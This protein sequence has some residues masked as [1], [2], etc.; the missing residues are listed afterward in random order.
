[1]SILQPA[2]EPVTRPWLMRIISGLHAGASRPLAEQE[3]LL[4]GSGDDCDVVLADNGVARH[5][6]LVALTGD[7]FTIRALDA[8]L[9]VGERPLYP[10]DPVALQP[11]Q[12]IGLGEAALAVG[13]EGDYGWANLAPSVTRID[14][15]EMPQGLPATALARRRG[16]R[17]PLIG[18][19]AAATIAGM[20]I[21]LALVGRPGPPTQPE[22]VVEDILREFQ[23][24][25]GR[26]E[27]NPEGEITITGT[28]VDQSAQQQLGQRLDEAGISV[29][30]KLLTEESIARNVAEVFRAEGEDVTARY[31]S[32][33]E[34][35]VT[36]YFRD[37]ERTRAIAQSRTMREV[38]GVRSIKPVNLGQRPGGAGAAD[39]QAGAAGRRGQRAI[40]VRL[41]GTEAIE[42]ADG[43]Q[44]RVGMDVPGWG[45]LFMITTTDARVQTAQGAVEKITLQP[46]PSFVDVIVGDGAQLIQQATANPDDG[47]LTIGEAPQSAPAEAPPVANTTPPAGSATPPQ[48]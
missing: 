34:V 19:L 18:A 26:V 15:L 36:G 45:R 29:N 39:G 42:A 9:H 40:I 5:H 10:G 23:V 6:A 47:D 20:A 32:N 27:V 21:L 41:I 24:A 8:P 1:M 7:G 3:T 44:Y 4:I 2:S 48:K 37:P 38:P 17:W 22:V 46:K 16:R 12:R 28:I 43:Q 35:E 11:L 14:G 33:G 30:N 13:K 31:V 25:G